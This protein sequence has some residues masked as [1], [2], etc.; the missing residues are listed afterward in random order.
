MQKMVNL[1]AKIFAMLRQW[2]DLS[3]AIGINI[4]IVYVI[5][6]KGYSI[7]RWFVEQ[8]L[9]LCIPVSNDSSFGHL[10]LHQPQCVCEYISLVLSLSLVGH[11]SLFLYFGL[12]LFMQ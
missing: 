2:S 8:M 4:H 5:I 10:L 6:S 3:F 7:Q 12:W 11:Q 9:P 1:M